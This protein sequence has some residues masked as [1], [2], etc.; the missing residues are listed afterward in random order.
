MYMEIVMIS[1]SDLKNL[2][3][4]Y[5]HDFRTKGTNGYYTSREYEDAIYTLYKDIC[6]ASYDILM[7]IHPFNNLAAELHAFLMAVFAIKADLCGDSEEDVLT[8]II[9]VI[10][11]LHGE[12]YSKIS[13]VISQRIGIYRAYYEEGRMNPFTSSVSRRYTKHS[14]LHFM[15]FYFQTILSENTSWFVLSKK[16]F[17]KKLLLPFT[18]YLDSLGNWID[19]SGAFSANNK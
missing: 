2:I 15:S 10:S 13:A 1:S 17:L 12:Q 19:D 14:D 4:P 8:Q 5:S 11:D 16:R 6:Q 18:Y 3:I 9:Y 7:K